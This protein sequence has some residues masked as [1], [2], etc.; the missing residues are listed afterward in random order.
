MKKRV[1]KKKVVRNAYNFLGKSINYP[2]KALIY[3]EYFQVQSY[4][5]LQAI[6]NEVPNEQEL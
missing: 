1:L 4:Q 6:L 3:G 5:E 2:I